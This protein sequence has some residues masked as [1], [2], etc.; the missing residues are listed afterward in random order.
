MLS[1]KDNSTQYN[2]SLI[3]LITLKKGVIYPQ[4]EA[5]LAFGRDV[6]IASINMAVKNSS[7]V[8]FVSQKSTTKKNPQKIDLYQ[9]GTIAEIIKTLPVNNELHALVK[10][11]YKVNIHTIE[12]KN[13]SLM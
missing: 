2:T 10:G 4:T 12:E 5:I 9:V 1:S 7:L 13:K 8:C 6:S 3:P 11:L